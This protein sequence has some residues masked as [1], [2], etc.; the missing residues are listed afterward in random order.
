[1]RWAAGTAG[2]IDHEQV[3]AGILLASDVSIVPVRKHDSAMTPAHL[4]ISRL[5]KLG[6][7]SHVPYMELGLAASCNKLVTAVTLPIE[8]INCMM[9]KSSCAK[10]GPSALPTDTVSIH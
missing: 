4:L 9:C 10:R 3:I 7:P 5:S 2:S 8:T 1:M 6:L